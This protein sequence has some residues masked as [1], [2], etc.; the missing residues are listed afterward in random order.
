MRASWIFQRGWPKAG[1]L[2]DSFSLA[3]KNEKKG[4]TT[5]M[6]ESGSG[7]NELT[8]RNNKTLEKEGVQIALEEG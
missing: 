5:L 1:K 3:H 4:G 2:G 7:G 6:E 8:S